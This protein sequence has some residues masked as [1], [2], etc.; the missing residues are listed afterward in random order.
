VRRSVCIEP[1]C[2]NLR[3]CPAHRAT[4]TGRSP[5]R[6]RGKQAEFRARVLA[7]DGYACTE[8]GAT[9]DLRACHVVPL[10]QGGGYDLANGVCR[11]RA[12]DRQTDPYAR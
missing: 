3:P 7:R 10:S 11:C 12:C 5:L 4:H 1:G 2:P 9:T 8:C 6:D